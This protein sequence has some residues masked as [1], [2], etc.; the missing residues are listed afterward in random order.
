MLRSVA[1]ILGFCGVVRAYCGTPTPSEYGLSVHRALAIRDTPA[2]KKRDTIGVE[3]FVH[4]I[5]NSTEDDNL[6]GQTLEQ[7][8]MLNQVFLDTGFAFTLAGFDTPIVERPGPIWVGSE[9]DAAIKQYRVGGAQTLDLYIVHE[10]AEGY[11]GYA[12]F[13]WEYIENPHLDGVVVQRPNIPGGSDIGLNTGK[14][15]AH[16]VGHWLGLLHTF[17]GGCDGEGDYVGDTP[18]EAFR[19]EGCPEGRETC[20]GAGGDPIHNYMDYTNDACQ[21]HFTQGQIARMAQVWEQ[22]RA[23]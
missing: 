9:G 20:L 7:I 6:H 15:A 14:R 18:A 13:P 17:E 12:T 2:L 22:F 3:V 8:D 5:R 11:A 19:A 10:V 23:G 4:V 16:E 1:A 21:T